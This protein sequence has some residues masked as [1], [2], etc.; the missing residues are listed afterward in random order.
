MTKPNRHELA[1]MGRWLLDGDTG[2]SSLAL[3]S[4][5]LTSG[6]QGECACRLPAPSDPSDFGRCYNFLRICVKPEKRNTLIN[7]IGEM[8]DNWKKVK[9]NWVELVDIYKKEE[10]FSEAPELY[11]FMKKIGL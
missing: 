11:K 9:T 3:C 8:T 4:F 10:K 7:E 6:N 5:Y 2:L 1:Q